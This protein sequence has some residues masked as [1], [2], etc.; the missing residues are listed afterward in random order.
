MATK[1]KPLVPDR[2]QKI[3][4]RR[5]QIIAAARLCFR[6]HG[7]HGAGMAEIAAQSQLSVGQIYRY[8]TN[9]EAII[10]EIAHRI[11]KHRVQLMLDNDNNLEHM[12]SA[13]ADHRLLDGDET[14]INQA[15]MLEV[16]AEATRNPRIARILLDVDAVLFREGCKMLMQA[17]P[18]MSH[19][20]AASLAEL[21]AVLTEGTM[22]RILT[23]QRQTTHKGLQ[24]IYLNLFSAVFPA[25]PETAPE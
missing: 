17:Y 3:A 16:S 21:M 20:A 12:A 11:V 7:F 18:E 9:K 25:R 1:N 8:F 19:D 24:Q 22:L 4:D 10:E 5:D 13:L 14:E 2:Q 15:L 23:Q 6:K